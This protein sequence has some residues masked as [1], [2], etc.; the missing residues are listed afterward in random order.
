MSFNIMS[1]RDLSSE[2]GPPGKPANDNTKAAPAPA[3]PVKTSA[4]GATK[5]ATAPRKS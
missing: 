5:G 2:T 3:K 1:F 4:K